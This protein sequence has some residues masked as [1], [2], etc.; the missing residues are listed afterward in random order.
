V[1]LGG[2]LGALRKILK[3]N[4]SRDLP[5]QVQKCNTKYNNKSI[6]V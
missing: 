1:N 5:S 3:K 2:V 6:A 4:N